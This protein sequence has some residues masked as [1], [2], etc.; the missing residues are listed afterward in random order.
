MGMNTLS[1]YSRS[2]LSRLLIMLI[3]L[4][5]CSPKQPSGP[6][7]RMRLQVGEITEIR[8]AR[9]TDRTAVLTGTSDNSEIVDVSLKQT[10]AAET[11]ATP[12]ADQVVYLIKGITVGTARVVFSEKRADGSGTGH[13]Q[14]TYVVQVSSK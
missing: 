10:V 6:T 4:T 5:A 9:P 2:L 8:V 1:P 11:G 7:K 13:V 14:K 3:G 12:S